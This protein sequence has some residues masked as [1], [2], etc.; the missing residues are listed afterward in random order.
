VLSNHR[1]LLQQNDRYFQWQ[2]D[3]SSIMSSPVSTGSYVFLAVSSVVNLVYLV[4]FV[5]LVGLVDL[6]CYF[7]KHRR[8]LRLMVLFC[9]TKVRDEEVKA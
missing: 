9:N 6:V 8:Q 1:E 7:H 4:C 2:Y 5:Y 3:T